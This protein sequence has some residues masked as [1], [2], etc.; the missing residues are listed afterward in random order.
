MKN[1]LVATTIAVGLT[2]VG[3]LLVASSCSSKSSSDAAP[4]P[5][6]AADT[7]TDNG[8]M[9]TIVAVPAPGTVTPAGVGDLVNVTMQLEPQRALGGRVKDGDQVAIMASF[10]SPDRTNVLAE[11]VAVAA[12]Q[13]DSSSD[14]GENADAAPHGNLLV[15][16]AVA[17]ADASRIVF[18]LEYGRVWLAGETGATA[19]LGNP[20]VS[21][22]NVT[23]VVA[24]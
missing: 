24:S 5:A 8:T 22:A 16:V 13:S 20:A 1:K 18:A 15:T 2:L 23:P 19:P 17:P 7:G 9:N 3:F 4:P 11:K 6:V 12:I 21:A 10:A 14:K